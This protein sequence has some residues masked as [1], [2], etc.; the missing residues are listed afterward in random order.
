MYKTIV[1]LLAFV[2]VIVLAHGEG[3]QW[4]EYVNRRFGFSLR[5]PATLI[6][7]RA[8]ENGAGLEFHTADKE[9][10]VLAEGHFLHVDE[11]DSFDKHWQDELDWIGGTITYK[12]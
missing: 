9:F 3:A 5:Y 1:I 2:L 4:K 11:G 10:S 12:K 6:A 7:S 8:P